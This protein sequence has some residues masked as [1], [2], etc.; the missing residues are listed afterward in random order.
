MVTEELYDI[1]QSL[2]DAE[3]LAPGKWRGVGY[4][5]R[6]IRNRGGCPVADCDGGRKGRSLKSP[7]NLKRH[8]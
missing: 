2:D 7:W 1:G 5:E 8:T 3:S 6:E 4:H